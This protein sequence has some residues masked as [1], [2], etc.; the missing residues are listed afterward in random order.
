MRISIWITA[1]FALIGAVLVGIAGQFL[2][3]P[4]L[5]LLAAAGF[6]AA[7]ITPNADGE[8]DVTTF[9]YTL[10]RNADVSLVLVNAD[11]R[12]FVFRA[13]QPR[14]A[15]AY[16][17]PF[18][19]VVN[20][21]TLPDETLG[22]TVERRLMPNGD[23]TW[24]LTATNAAETQTLSGM[25]TLQAGDSPLPIISSFTVGPTTFSPNQ[26]GIDDRVEVNV[27]LEKEADL[28]VFLLGAEGREYPIAARKE[29]R[30]AGEAG[31]HTFDYDGGV[32]L[33]AEPPPDG[34]YTV[35]AIAQDAVGQ[36]MRVETQLTIELGGKPFAEI[37][38]QAVGADV[39][40]IAAPYAE[41]YFSTAEQRGALV[42]PP[43][44]PAALEVAPITMQVGDVL[45]FQLTIENYSD[46]PLR[47][48]GP[49]P[50]TVY[51]Q[52]QTSAAMGYFTSA[53]AWRVGLQCET[54][55]QSFPYRWAI[56][57]PDVLDAVESPSGETF[58]YLAPGKRSVVWGAIRLT[59]IQPL[60]N[61]QACW[62]GLIHEGVEI[63]VYN[64][65]VGR[66]DIRL[67]DPNA[68]T[69]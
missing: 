67:V 46:V 54:S 3:N 7:L 42:D 61:P 23:Y 59:E 26:D 27:Y 34:T 69:E 15:G 55:A 9:R 43:T 29:G 4:N 47:T 62:A 16:S 52:E 50:G 64:S 28:R 56:G 13:D 8:Q 33:N 35:V 11:G 20:G 18:S 57:T 39:M 49:Q 58:Y 38:P 1:L 22:G 37:V 19:G 53:G 12:E 32:D 17:V 60:Q 6:D 65:N 24:R 2:V 30:K 45:I 21:Y 25:L 68:A 36:R 31:R 41:R 14:A 63:S 51:S 40:L 48:T 66:R 44:D 5:P 10:H